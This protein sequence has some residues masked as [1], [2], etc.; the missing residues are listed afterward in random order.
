MSHPF[1]AFFLKHETNPQ[2][3]KLKNPL[4]V[5][6]TFLPTTRRP[7]TLESAYVC[8]SRGVYYRL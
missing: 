3:S 2:I 6:G 1:D 8:A 7:N 4:C 5:C